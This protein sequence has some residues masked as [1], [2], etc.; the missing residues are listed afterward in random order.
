MHI[1]VTFILINKLILNFK[2]LLD[3]F[4]TTIK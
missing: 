2:K 3:F 4:M 1:I